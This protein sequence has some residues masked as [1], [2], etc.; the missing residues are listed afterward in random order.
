MA[1]LN[2]TEDGFFCNWTAP[3]LQHM[4]LTIVKWILTQL[5]QLWN[6]R[7]VE[8]LI[9]CMIFD[10]NNNKSTSLYFFFFFRRMNCHEFQTKKIIQRVEKARLR[11]SFSPRIVGMF[12]R[13]RRNSPLD[14]HALGHTNV[15]FTMQKYVHNDTETKKRGIAAMA[16]II[17]WLLCCEGNF[18]MFPALPV[19]FGMVCHKHRKWKLH[20]AP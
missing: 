20:F 15:A 1:F 18:F 10:K 13:K 19:W 3:F 17:W 8:T 14:R 12:P 7:K 5:Y 6:W 2:C 11:W 9:I 16:D 4:K